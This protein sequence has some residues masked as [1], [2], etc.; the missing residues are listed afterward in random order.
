VDLREGL[1][2]TLAHYEERRSSETRTSA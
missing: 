1:A 2:R